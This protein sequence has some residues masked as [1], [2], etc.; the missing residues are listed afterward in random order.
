MNK[1]VSGIRVGVGMF[2][3]LSATAQATTVYNVQSTSIV[4]CGSA[5]HGLWTG[6]QK[7][8][9]G[10]CGDY[11]DISGAHTVNDDNADTNNWTGNFNAFAINPQGTTANI[12]LTFFRTLRR[13][14]STRPRVA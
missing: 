1:W 12:A 7:F 10:S 9:G 14:R 6:Q 2:A 8:S 13:L 11:Y 4:N 3:G 5:S